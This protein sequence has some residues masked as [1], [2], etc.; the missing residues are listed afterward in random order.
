MG[1]LWELT[2][3]AGS[4]KSKATTLPPS[5]GAALGEGTERGAEC[6]RGPG[7]D[8]L[9]LVVVEGGA[10]EV[11]NLEPCVEVEDP[12]QAVPGPPRGKEKKDL[13]SGEKKELSP[14]SA[15]APPPPGQNFS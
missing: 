12:R 14:A 7:V 1:G 9:D 3:S 5:P 8:E 10:G 11:V 15:F 4:V 2:R 13:G 6:M